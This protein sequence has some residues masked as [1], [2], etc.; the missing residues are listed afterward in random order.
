MELLAFLR[1][2]KYENVEV[3]FKNGE[4]ELFEGLER[5]DNNARIKEILEKEDYQDIQIIRQ[6]GKV[7]AILSK[8][9][10]KF[11]KGKNPR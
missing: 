11:T 4:M 9:K 5:H 6:D 2:G 10:K 3:K 1:I 7:T 8:T